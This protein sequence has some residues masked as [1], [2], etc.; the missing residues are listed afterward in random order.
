MESMRLII[1]EAAAGIIVTN[2]NHRLHRTRRMDSAL[3]LARFDCIVAV[4]RSLGFNYIPFRINFVTAEAC[5]RTII[6]IGRNLP[7]L[8]HTAAEA[9]HLGCN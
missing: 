4:L 5:L 2:S 6:V 3:L 7:W 9:F 8:C 1:K